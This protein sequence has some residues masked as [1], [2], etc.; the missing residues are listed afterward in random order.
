[1]DFLRMLI[2]RPG[3]LFDEI[4]SKATYWRYTDLIFFLNAFLGGLIITIDTNAGWFSE[5]NLI[6]FIGLVIVI[7][8]MT[9]IFLQ[10]VFVWIFLIIGKI[11][12]GK[13]NMKQLMSVIAVGFIPNLVVVLYQLVYLLATKN[14][15]TQYHLPL[16]IS[17][18]IW[19]ILIYYI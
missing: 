4:F 13:A 18:I 19:L 7:V 3:S 1:M 11:L 17:S 14:I 5:P 6:A 8:F 10:F 16:A 9:W 2:F 15:G 12:C